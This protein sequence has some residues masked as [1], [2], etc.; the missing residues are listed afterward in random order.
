M[1]PAEIT[2]RRT[3][4]CAVAAFVVVALLVTGV[5]WVG[6]RE[7]APQVSGDVGA[8][9]SVGG[10]A[11]PDLAPSPGRSDRAEG[12]RPVVEV[13]RAGRLE[14]FGTV[15]DAA[16]RRPVVGA[17]VWTIARPT[18]TDP[19]P[20]AS[21]TT[22]GEG[23]F[24]LRASGDPTGSSAPV[25]VLV[26]VLARGYRPHVRVESIAVAGS[27]VRV[28]LF[29]GATIE[30]SVVDESGGAIA[31]AT[32]RAMG[33]LGEEVRSSAADGVA[34]FTLTRP[35]DFG[36]AVTDA[37]G[38]FA[39]AGL[40]EGHDYRLVARHPAYAAP[41]VT[42]PPPP[43]RPG[44]PAIVRMKRL[45]GVRVV[46]VDEVTWAPV[47][48]SSLRFGQGSARTDPNTDAPFVESLLESLSAGGIASD[49]RRQVV[50]AIFG[51]VA[52]SVVARAS[53]PGYE[54]ADVELPLERW[55]ATTRSVRLR[56][57]GGDRVRELP[58][59]L[60]F[61]GGRTF[62]GLL[63]VTYGRP[64]TPHMLGSLLRFR[65][66]RSLD[67]LPVDTTLRDLE[68]DTG[69]FAQATGY[70]DRPGRAVTVD[71]T[72]VDA[73]RLELRGARV[74]LRVRDASG[75]T[76]RG[77]QLSIAGGESIGV[78]Q[79][80]VADQQEP[81]FIASDG[82]VGF[83]LGEM[84]AHL[85]VRKVGYRDVR[86]DVVVPADGSTVD[87]DVVLEAEGG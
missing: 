38:R 55:P 10:T 33:L 7:V 22:D 80:W 54:S 85:G 12:P 74:R 18:D 72:T 17:S 60:K 40:V 79:T 13:L 51:T 64:G 77:F 61:P 78:P 82:S 62:D 65:G 29:S 35:P 30:G 19:S 67:T 66:G 16:S 28:E 26:A 43:T 20:R 31:G 23:R 48:G 25:A 70:W 53:A 27:E 46:V 6:F 1:T 87:V 56:R 4:G 73:L 57:L 24:V 63:F 41:V 49:G 59:I 2:R 84:T 9:R 71:A 11:S 50:T 75:D 21:V 34:P 14:L 42:S 47:R 36:S 58:V 83:W 68:Y 76:L 5:W 44:Q 3:A 69:G 52:P 86:R 15:L 8:S 32:V 39:I 37:G 81:G 45:F